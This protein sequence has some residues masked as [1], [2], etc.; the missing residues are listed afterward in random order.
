MRSSASSHLLSTDKER[1]TEVYIYEGHLGGLYGLY[2]LLDYDDLY[3]EQCGDS[4]RELGY[5]ESSA[6]ILTL[7]ADDID[8]PSGS[9]GWALD[10]VLELVAECFPDEELS[11]EQ[12][13]EIIANART[14][15]ESEDENGRVY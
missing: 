10:Y 11:K 13:L 8:W 14:D 6:D 7:L 3:C 4:D 15:D 5:V 2:D 9:G 12:A 1:K